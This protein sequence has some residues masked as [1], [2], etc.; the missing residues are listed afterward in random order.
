MSVTAGPKIK[1][2]VLILLLFVAAV[3]SGGCWDR[4]EIE[5]IAFIN[6]VG[7]DQAGS[8]NVLVTFYVVNPDALSK[9]GGGGAPPAI[10]TSVEARDVAL[11]VAR[12]A[13]LSPR[14]PQFKQLQA[15]IIGE[16][17]ARQGVGPV[18]D[19]F[20]R[21]QEMRR[22]IWVL[23][24]KGK[25]QDILVKGQSPP[26]KLASS[27]IR[28]ILERRPIHS[29][30][31]YPVVLGDLL[32]D[33]SRPGMEPIASSVEISPLRE[34]TT[35]GAYGGDGGLTAAEGSAAEE[36]KVIALR[37]AGVFRDEK[38]LDFLG[39][40][41]T[42]GVLW[43]QGK[44]NGGRVVVPAPGQGDWA[45]LAIERESTDVKPVVEANKIRFVVNIREEGYVISV[46]NEKIKVGN[47]DTI[48][49]LEQEKQTAIRQE[50]LGAVSKAKSLQSDFLGLGDRLYRKYPGVWKQVK[51]N[52]NTA[53]LPQ[54]EVDVS[55]KCKLRN[56]SATNDPLNAGEKG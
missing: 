22:S 24:A 43:V 13:E 49:L 25:A 17:L 54:V 16:D 3:C 34:A 27:G 7:V 38:L 32:S 47:L 5:N 15:I 39:P 1:N 31:R 41:E 40:S 6:A 18:L 29:A 37:G 14:L 36:N 56:T 10:V 55:V 48:E 50:V 53:W 44:V 30:T 21:R 4:M 19:Y 11:A 23:V 20:S 46:D 12:Y 28:I 8:G 42:R 9:K 51:D 52:W 45:S 33:V 35:G 2:T 26:E